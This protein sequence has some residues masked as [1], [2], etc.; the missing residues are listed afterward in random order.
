MLP[1]WP[2]KLTIMGD[3]RAADARDQAPSHPRRDERSRPRRR[4]PGAVGP[5]R[6]SATVATVLVALLDAVLAAKLAPEV[7]L[8]GVHK[9]VGDVV[10]ERQRPDPNDEDRAR[11]RDP[12]D[13]HVVPEAP[14]WA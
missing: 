7:P 1:R 9:C 8:P 6:H 12:E 5:G 3:R 11:H 14:N 10:G 13:R 2:M 4:V